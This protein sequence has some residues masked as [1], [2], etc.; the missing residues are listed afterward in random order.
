MPSGNA[1]KYLSEYFD[2]SKEYKSPY[3]VDPYNVDS[4]CINPTGKVL[5]GNIYE[6]DIL[7]IMKKYQEKI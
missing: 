5:S 6:Q 2:L 7:E 1:R 4:I 3:A